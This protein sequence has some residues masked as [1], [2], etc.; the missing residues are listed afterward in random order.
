M[1]AMVQA[2]LVTSG[3]AVFLVTGLFVPAVSGVFWI[4]VMIA[5][6]DINLMASSEYWSGINFN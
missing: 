3:F 6:V 1:I 4:T 5:M 2:N